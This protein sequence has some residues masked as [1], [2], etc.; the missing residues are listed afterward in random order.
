MQIQLDTQI[1]ILRGQLSQQLARRGAQD[2]YVEH[3]R[4]QIAS[5]ERQARRRGTDAA[6]ASSS[7]HPGRSSRDPASDS[8]PRS[9]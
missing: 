7:S 5:L 2:P 6:G 9:A 3:L 1:E 8:R 4:W